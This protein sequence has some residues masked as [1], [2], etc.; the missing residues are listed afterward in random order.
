MTGT[1]AD[2]G[3]SIRVLTQYAAAG[4]SHYPGTTLTSLWEVLATQ[5]FAQSGK[6]ITNQA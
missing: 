3:G 2:T 1:Y 4:G 5:F 6:K